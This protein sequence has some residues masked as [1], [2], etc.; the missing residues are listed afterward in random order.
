MA[1]Q[2]LALSELALLTS[3]LHLSTCAA[4]PHCPSHR[5]RCCRTSPLPTGDA[6][7]GRAGWVRRGGG[8]A[9]AVVAGGHGANVVIMVAVLATVII[10][11]TAIAT[12]T[13]PTVLVSAVNATITND[14]VAG[15]EG[16][17]SSSILLSPPLFV[18]LE[19]SA[20]PTSLRTPQTRPFACRHPLMPRWSRRCRPPPPPP[21]RCHRRCDRPT[22]CFCKTT[23][24]PLS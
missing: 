1:D 5:R 15:G 23:L 12:S 8:G 2:T 22:A 4:P 13:A 19:P 3:S 16:G 18:Q 9:V 24:P 17:G 7:E 10:V 14:A 11:T 20:L 21:P 6:R